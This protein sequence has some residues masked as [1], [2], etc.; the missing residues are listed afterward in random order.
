MRERKLDVSGERS[1]T[2]YLGIK[3]VF[4][5]SFGRNLVL[6]GSDPQHRKKHVTSIRHAIPG[7]ETLRGLRFED[8]RLVAVLTTVATRCQRAPVQ[9]ERPGLN[10]PTVIGIII[11]MTVAMMLTMVM[12]RLTRFEA[13]PEVASQYYR[14]VWY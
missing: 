9:N 2:P 7:N 5:T 13:S 6:A 12:L 10:K 8:D 11:H 4:E 1:P 14:Q 3:L